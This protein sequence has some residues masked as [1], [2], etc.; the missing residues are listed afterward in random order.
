MCLTLVGTV[1]LLY[2]RTA[3]FD[4]VSLDDQEFITGNPFVRGGLTWRDIAWS[5]TALAP[6]WHPVTW[7]THMADIE[8]FGLWAGGHHLV[9]VGYHATNSVL[10]FLALRLMTGAL[11]PSALA[12]ALFAL[13]PLRVESVAWLAERKDVVSGCWFMLTLIAYGWYARRPATGR[14]LLVALALALGLMSKTMLVSLPIIL[15]LLDVWPLGRVALSR[16]GAWCLDGAAARR[17]LHLGLEKGP[18]L[19]LSAAASLLTIRTQ[20]HV[21]ALRGMAEV[22]LA[23]RLANA[24]LAAVAYLRKS[25]WPNDLAGFYPHPALI[26][27]PVADAVVPALLA[28]ALLVAVSIAC[29]TVLPRRPY[30]AVGWFW[31]LAALLPVI[32]LVQVGMQAMADRYTY[33]SMPGL[34]AA[35]AWTL[36]DL[37]AARPALRSAVAAGALAALAASAAVTWRQVDTWRDSE[38]LFTHA[39]AVTDG[40]FLAHASLGAILSAAGR[41]TEAEHHLR[42]A[43][44]LRERDPYAQMQLGTLLQDGGRLEEAAAHHEA[45]LR[46]SPSYAQALANLGIVRVRQQRFGEAERHLRAALQVDPAYALAYTN[47]GALLLQQRRWADGAAALRQAIA[48]DPTSAEAH[49]NLGVALANL[50][51]LSGAEA[52]LVAALRLRPDYANAARALEHVR[53]RS[54][55]R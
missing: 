39:L 6:N 18:L 46:F 4:F 55:R 13:H 11:W 5:I 36:R 26:G 29:L 7:W 41:A 52:E 8:A 37:V 28:A 45:A 44:R 33:L 35:V 16:D 54:A 22:P 15:L 23:W 49:N 3:Q 38:S 2:G 51:D 1:L 25:A 50:G 34:Y 27:Q 43:L 12:A 14:Y 9:S 24:P 17:L 30:L 53:S 47:L 20:D 40:N 21:A 42:Q 31:Y 48:L 10:L 32:G 19:A